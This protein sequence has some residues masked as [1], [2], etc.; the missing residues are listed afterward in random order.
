Q[1]GLDD[2]VQ[3]CRSRL[4]PVHMLPP[5]FLVL[6]FRYCTADQVT[7]LHY[8]YGYGALSHVCRRWRIVA[9]DAPKLWTHIDAS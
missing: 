4:A 1:K 5:E 2:V 6:V 7:P 3:R 9:F 8:L